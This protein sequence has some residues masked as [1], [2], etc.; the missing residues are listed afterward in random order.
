MDQNKTP[1]LAIEGLSERDQTEEVEN[2][3]DTTHSQDITST[4][5]LNPLQS[6]IEPIEREKV[7]TALPITSE[8]TS[9]DPSHTPIFLVS[10]EYNDDDMLIPGESFVNP[11]ACI[12]IPSSTSVEPPVKAVNK[13]S[14]RTL[15]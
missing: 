11:T 12:P 3:H 9:S 10:G 15:S 4:P 1:T 2:R 7:M 8:T 14:A 6:V 13:S 5:S